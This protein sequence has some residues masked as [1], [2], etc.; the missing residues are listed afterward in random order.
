M[1]NRVE[2]AVAFYAFIALIGWVPAAVAQPCPGDLNGD[3]QVTVEELVSAVNAALNG[4]DG[5][6][7]TRTPTRVR[8]P[9]RTVPA[10]PS[11]TPTSTPQPP[12]RFVDNGDGTITDGETGLLW[13]KKVALNGAPGGRH[14]ADNEYRWAGMCSP[15][16]FP[17]K[18][19]QPDAASAAACTASV[20][21][22]AVACTQCSGRGE[23]CLSSPGGTSNFT[24]VWGLVADLNAGKG[25]AGHRDWRV[26]T[27]DELL[28]IND[29][30]H[31][32]FN[33]FIDD[34]GT[35]N[36]QACT[37]GCADLSST[38]CS[39]TQSGFHWSSTTFENTDAW[40]VYP[41][42]PNPIATYHNQYF[43]PE[44]VRAVRGGQ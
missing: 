32:T 24:T 37:A 22:D 8:T 39:C 14:D 6:N 43:L 34:S 18:F 38:A 9:T 44:P 40:L 27:L 31:Y 5:A 41:G 3:R 13:E 21:G 23:T 35:F 36:T 10:A 7:V 12:R 16:T 26:P 1:Y 25:F 4:C 33:P 20:D 11:H 42:V 15:T 2:S 30:R 17:P 19:C 28:S 29:A